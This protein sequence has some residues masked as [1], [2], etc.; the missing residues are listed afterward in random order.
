MGT[1][2]FLPALPIEPPA[3]CIDGTTPHSTEYYQGSG[4]NNP[5]ADWYNPT[6]LQWLAVAP[7]AVFQFAVVP[8]GGYKNMD[9]ARDDVE[10][11]AGWLAEA[12]T[13]IGAG[14]ATTVD[15]GRFENVEWIV[16]QPSP[17]Q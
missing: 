5:P 7:G 17:K 15:R 4:N 3:L 16:G 1:V 11:A 6:P 8:R 14:A 9:S 2:D 10:A 12:L 13:T